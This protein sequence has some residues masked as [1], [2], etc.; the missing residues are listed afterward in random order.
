MCGENVLLRE[1]KAELEEAFMAEIE[2]VNVPAATVKAQCEAIL[3]A[4]GMSDEHVKM[5]ADVLLETDL[6]GIES[7]GLS[8]LPIYNDMRGKKINMTPNIRVVKETP[9]SALIDADNGIG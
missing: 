4:W 8:M 7:H 1:R 6:R 2:M 5:T 3:R 9:V